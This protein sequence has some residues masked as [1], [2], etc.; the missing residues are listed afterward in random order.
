MRSPQETAGPGAPSVELE[1]VSFVYPDGTRALAEVGLRIEPGE[2][3]AI[4]G[5]NGSGKSTLARH[6]NG[7]L[8]PTA[9]RVLL[10][11]AD[12]RSL[13]VA[14]LAGLVGLAF[15]NPDRQLFAG[16]VA[17]EVA[18]GPRNLGV[19]GAALDERVRSALEVVGLG[20]EA[21]S[22]PYDLGYSR[23]KL[24]SLASVLAMRTPILVLD[25][26]TTGQDARGSAR[27]REVVAAALAEGRTVIAISHDMRFAAECF[28][29]VIVMKAGRAILDGS[30]AVAFGE[31][32]WPELRATF[33]EPPLAAVAGSRL[34]LGS[35][36]TS[37]SLAAALTRR[38]GA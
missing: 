8:R 13:H 23:R 12:A 19:R 3:V 4:V 14:R 1:G 27:V 32:A 2:S 5:Q 37:A 9:G 24:L 33:L 15:Q 36:P 34:G 29:R 26:P 31:G 22:N 35:T 11:G 25:E 10:D 28:R 38:T 21:D 20:G 18:F 6:L 7:L 30:P 17:A 16:R